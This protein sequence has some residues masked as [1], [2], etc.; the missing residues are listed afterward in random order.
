MTFED[1]RKKEI[2]LILVSFNANRSFV[3]FGPQFNPTMFLHN[4]ES[5]ELFGCKPFEKNS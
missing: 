5:C 2:D 4:L 3:N 1:K